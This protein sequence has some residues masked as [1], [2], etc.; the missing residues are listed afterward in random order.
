MGEIRKLGKPTDWANPNDYIE[1]R[2]F[3][4]QRGRDAYNEAAERYGYDDPAVKA[5]RATLEANHVPVANV[6][7][8]GVK[9]ITPAGTFNLP[10]ADAPAKGAKVSFAAPVAGP[11]TSRRGPRNIGDGPMGA[12]S[13][14][15]GGDDIGVPAGT[16]PTSRHHR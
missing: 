16:V 10:K 11:V 5:M 6:A 8:S 1:N 15:H 9:L 3:Q 2:A 14:D 4:E 7:P 13:R 12:T